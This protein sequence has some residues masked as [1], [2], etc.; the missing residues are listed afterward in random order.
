M[1]D[2]KVHFDEWKKVWWPIWQIFCQNVQRQIGTNVGAQICVKIAAKFGAEKGVKFHQHF[3]KFPFTNFAFE[4]YSE[5]VT[6]T[7]R[8]RT[9]TEVSV[10]N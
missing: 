6:A 8:S 4:K 10:E 5:A 7:S 9:P 1:I 3:E 2:F